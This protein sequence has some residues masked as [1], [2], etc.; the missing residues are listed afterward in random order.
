MMRT[1][2]MRHGFQIECIIV[3]RTFVLRLGLAMRGL[4][5]FSIRWSLRSLVIDAFV[6]RPGFST[7][8]TLVQGEKTLRHDFRKG[9]INFSTSEGSLRAGVHKKCNAPRFRNALSLG[10]LGKLGAHGKHEKFFNSLSA[11]EL[12]RKVY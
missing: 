9:L 11:L 4:I 5:N 12:R 6:M 10:D 3:I 8:K 1:F 7:R 2:V